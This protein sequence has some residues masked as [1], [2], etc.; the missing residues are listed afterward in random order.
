MTLCISNG[1]KAEG[2]SRCTLYYWKRTTTTDRSTT[3]SCVSV[4]RWRIYLGLVL[5]AGI[6]VE[7][8]LF[9]IYIRWHFVCL[10][11]YSCS[12]LFVSNL[13]ILGVVPRILILILTCAAPLSPSRRAKDIP[14][15]VESQERRVGRVCEGSAMCICIAA[16]L[17]LSLRL[18]LLLLH[19]KFIRQLQVKS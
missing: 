7:F 17:R 5:R 4:I 9:S 2:C 16:S 18:R 3:T 6:S 8:I 11:F 1:W 12:L 19:L 10:S 14:R 13:H 15:P